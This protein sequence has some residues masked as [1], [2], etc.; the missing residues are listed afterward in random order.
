M[1][2]KQ[3]YIDNI[4]SSPFTGKHIWLRELDVREYEYWKTN[5]YSHIFEDE[6]VALKTIKI[7]KKDGIS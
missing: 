3:E 5:G 7:N 2:I 1:I 4:V 6:P